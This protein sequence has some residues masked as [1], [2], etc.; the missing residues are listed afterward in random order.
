MTLYLGRQKIAPVVNTIDVALADATE[1]DVKKGKTF[2]SGDIDIKTGTLEVPDLS[3][4]TATTADVLQGKKFYNAQGELVE[5]SYV[6][7]D[8]LKTFLSGNNALEITADDLV[9]T[10]SIREY[11]FY[12]YPNEIQLTIPSNIKTIGKYAFGGCSKLTNLNFQENSQ[13]SDIGSYA[14]T[15]CGIK[16]LQIPKSVTT[17]GAS[18]FRGCQSIESLTFEQGCKVTKIDSYTF[19]DSTTT[20][21]EK[22]LQMVDLSTCV[23]LSE[24]KSRAFDVTGI[25]NM[26][27]P[28][29]LTKIENH[30]LPNTL[31]TLTVLSPTPPSLAY[32]ISSYVTDAVY[33]PKG[34]LSAYESATNWSSLTGKFVELEA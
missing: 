34:T 3:A 8:R 2:F 30:A 17:I 13:L 32:N 22:W 26:I 18:A 31:K 29:T 27:L 33:I 6:A 23:Q 21:L 12:Y 25:Y 5:G 20:I 4:T 16:S 11:S 9:D 28:Y 1:S 14:F 24:I 7:Q 19:Y 10:T 15:G